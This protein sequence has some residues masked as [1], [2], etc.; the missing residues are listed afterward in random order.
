MKGF[1]RTL[2]ICTVFCSSVV[3]AESDDS[4]NAEEYV[5]I[6]NESIE[7]VNLDA[8]Y[9][10]EFAQLAEKFAEQAD[11]STKAAAEY[12][13]FL[14]NYEENERKYIDHMKNA[15]EEA[16]K[17]VEKS[18]RLKDSPNDFLGRF[19]TS[20]ASDILDVGC[21]DGEVASFMARINPEATVIGIDIS[22]S[23]VE[24]AKESFSDQE[25]LF[26]AVQDV[27][28]LSLNGKFDLITSFNV[29]QW[30]QDQRK[31]LSSFYKSL[32][33]GGKL[34]IQMQAGLPRAMESALSDM[35]SSERWAEYF[36][37]FSPDWQLYQAREYGP[38]L[39]DAGFSIVRLQTFT[40]REIF[41]SREEF[42]GFLN[43]WLPHLNSIP[44]Y[45]HNAF[46]N[47][48]INFYLEEQTDDGKE[49][50]RFFVP[51]LEVVATK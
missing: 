16:E 28:S 12:A 11:K 38:L 21:G 2:S 13:K 4:L 18:E 45:L 20:F 10:E 9:A 48:L 5:E 36:T 32:A 40:K 8:K 27:Q 49:G 31:A 46:I 33:H 29:M 26:F 23:M 19:D 37:D 22:S 47:E 42:H 41:S 17:F 50:I 14:E 34:C 24:F 3:F 1:Y 44:P 6:T 25:N 35:V 15:A 43:E 30:V 39:K 51:A 7:V